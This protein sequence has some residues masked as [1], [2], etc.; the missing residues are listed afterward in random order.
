M[1]V[2]YGV[3]VHLSIMLHVFMSLYFSQIQQSAVYV[4][5]TACFIIALPFLGKYT[6]SRAALLG[7]VKVK[8][9]VDTMKAYCS[10][11]GM[12]PLILNLAAGWR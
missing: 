2:A 1:V 6:R 12:A 11:R 8:L 10:S 3:L 4:C 5:V 9:S 7:K